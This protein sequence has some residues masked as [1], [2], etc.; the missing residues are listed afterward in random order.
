MN[1]SDLPTQRRALREGALLLPA[2]HLGTL[3]IS[4][5]DRKTWLNGMIT[6]DLAPL[7]PGQGAYGFVVA[8]TGKLLAELFVLVAADR[9]L[10]SVLR[11][12]LELLREH[13][14]R[15]V[16][17]ED[18]EL[19]DASAEVAWIIAH[20]P[21][22]KAL[23]PLARDSGALAAAAVD[24]SGLGGAAI[25]LPVDGAEAAV[26][27][28]LEHAGAP[29]AIATSEGW[30]ALRVEIGLPRWGA[31][32]DDQNYPQ[33][34]SLEHLGVSFQKGCY[35]GQEA[36]FMLQMRGHVKKKLVPLA[37][38]GEADLDK[39][40]E[41]TLPD[42]TAVGAITSLTRSPDAPETLALGFVKW[43]HAAGGTA[44]AVAGRSARVLGKSDAS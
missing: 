38:E 29:V 37:I 15:Y 5:K 3:A 34:A 1:P 41:I 44:L 36:V 14:D 17:M 31:D 24:S 32:F 7:G 16:I 22:A 4:G 33:E 23:V 21:Q 39:G 9:L 26:S 6:C 40:A 19:E 13:F 28:L 8:K 20:G 35:L 18:V 43:K 2:P 25:A 12:R 10:V 27:R 42:G 30:E 11:E